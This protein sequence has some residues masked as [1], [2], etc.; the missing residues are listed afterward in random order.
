M[1]TTQKNMQQ[2]QAAI[3]AII[4]FVLISL[5]VVSSMSLL[6][7]SR[8]RAAG[9]LV[10]SKQ[11]YA[12][13]ES[14]VED[15][16]YRMVNQRKPFNVTPPTNYTPI[17]TAV[18][19]G[20][21]KLSFSTPDANG[22][23]SLSTAGSNVQSRYRKLNASVKLESC[24]GVAFEQGVQAGFLGFK[25]DSGFNLKNADE[26]NNPSSTE[27]GDIFSNG[28]MLDNDTGVNMWA[29][30]KVTLAQ[31]TTLGFNQFGIPEEYDS[32][33]TPQAV[34]DY[35]QSAYNESTSGFSGVAVA[36]SANT[37]DVAQSFIA[38]MTGY[39]T[40]V[41][42]YGSRQGTFDKTVSIRIFPT[43]YSTPTSNR[44]DPNMDPR[45]YAISTN[46]FNISTWGLQAAWYS[47]P[48]TTN[49]PVV[50]NEKYWVVF[51]TSSTGNGQNYYKFYSKLETNGYVPNNTCYGNDY[52]TSTVQP[53]PTTLGNSLP[54]SAGSFIRT[55]SYNTSNPVWT[56]D[57]VVGNH[58][59]IKFR[60]Y[61]GAAS[62][63]GA[64]AGTTHD[65]MPTAKRVVVGGNISS[66]INEDS[67]AAGTITR[68]D[69][70]NEIY[71]S[72]AATTTPGSPGGVHCLGESFPPCII[73]QTKSLF[74]TPINLGVPS[75]AKYTW[76]ES[77]HDIKTTALSVGT[78][79]TRGQTIGYGISPTYI[80]PHY[81][82][83]NVTIVDGTTIILLGRVPKQCGLLGNCGTV[84]PDGTGPLL[85]GS[86]F[87]ATSTSN[88]FSDIVPPVCPANITGE[89]CYIWYIRGNLTI[90]DACT[91]QT[92]DPNKKAFI[93]VDGGIT[94]GNGGAQICNFN[95]N[96]NGSIYLISLKKE[97]TT[98]NTATPNKTINFLG[99][100]G[101]NVALWA[102]L[103]EIFL[104]RKTS[105]IAL[106]A[107]RITTI[108]GT[109]IVYKTGAGDGAS[110][111]NSQTSLR[112]S[113]YFEGQ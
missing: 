97:V 63:G 22:V 100:I 79:G 46:G 62:L 108:N 73:Q 101:G 29:S 82:N 109:K 98:N 51:D 81:D 17:T 38:P 60:V 44:P 1:H 47:K 99:N 5:I 52:C 104:N 8:L 50:Q 34:K 33:A 42:V 78:R 94:I 67:R 54:G 61:F 113:S 4:F 88:S 13:S 20:T 45:S 112:F 26:I 43:D 87:T 7:F 16:G 9:E 49:L 105:A 53:D 6:A 107:P 15:I 31:P 58:A 96:S 77:V 48:L 11:A 14:G 69:D 3:T 95:L 55:A 57:P 37:T 84:D 35:M 25:F 90:P 92:D 21:A 72:Y 36:T 32:M 102:P 12:T 40:R 19:G 91:I 71:G 74:A 110:P 64:S 70:N 27:H 89:P 80:A 111:S 103:G 65:Y 2:G 106:S 59:D 28:H 41:D 93:V 56:G 83:G 10:I 76:E 68:Y 86:L 18:N 66:I 39:V 75:D 23:Y 24:K 30:G 85:P